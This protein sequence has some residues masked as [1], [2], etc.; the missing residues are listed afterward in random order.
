MLLQLKDDT[1]WQNLKNLEIIFFLRLTGSGS[2][3]EISLYNILQTP[4]QIIQ[5]RC[6]YYR[7]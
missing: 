6:Y 7:C 2:H 3:V 5:S 4:D 1:L